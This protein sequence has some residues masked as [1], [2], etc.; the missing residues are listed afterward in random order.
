MNSPETT[1]LSSSLL[2]R[3]GLS[4]V[5]VIHI[6]M[7]GWEAAWNSPTI[8]EPAYLASGVSHWEFGRFDLCKV[9]PPLVRLV[10]AI[11]V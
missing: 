9:S 10:A 7:L 1:N 3:V 6:V 8:D 5:I 11:P 4:L 2:T